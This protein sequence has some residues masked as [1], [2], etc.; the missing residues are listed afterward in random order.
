MADQLPAKT[1]GAEMPISTAPMT[2]TSVASLREKSTPDLIQAIRSPGDDAYIL[3]R[4]RACLS[5]FYEPEMD[6]KT[7]AAMMDEYPR[8]LGDLPRWAV[9]TAFDAWMRQHNRRPSP[10][11]IRILAENSIKNI[12]G[13][14]ARRGLRPD[15]SAPKTEGN[16]LSDLTPEQMAARRAQ[17]DAILAECNFGPERRKRIARHRTASSDAE[18]DE[19]EARRETLNS[20]PTR[21]AEGDPA[22][23]ALRRANPA[24]RAT[25][26]KIT[27]GEA[28][29]RI[30]AEAAR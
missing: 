16:S 28:Q 7:R 19:I 13:E 22:L 23:D 11:E 14:L 15:G 21:P 3:K 5:A 26:D 18:M 1:Q 17:A 30:A 6:P 25:I 2:N 8:A 24:I 10:A 27:L 12:T 29:Q 9:S 4:L 20:N